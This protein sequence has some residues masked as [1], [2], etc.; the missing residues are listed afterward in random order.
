M[1]FR[2]CIDGKSFLCTGDT[3]VPAE[4]G[5][6]GGKFKAKLGWM[7]SLELDKAKYIASLRKAC[8]IK[9]DVLLAG[10]GIP[11]MKNGSDVIGSALTKALETFR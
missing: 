5:D 7:G 3:V 4:G 6:Y 2:F 9:A 11:V 8:G 1:F 10:H